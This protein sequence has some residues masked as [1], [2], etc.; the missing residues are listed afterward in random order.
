M[1]KI[2]F[3]FTSEKAKELYNGKP[4][5]YETPFAS[6]FDLKRLRNSKNNTNR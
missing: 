1:Q 6:G 3:C 5:Q 4:P 2:K